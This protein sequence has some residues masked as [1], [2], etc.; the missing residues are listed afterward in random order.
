MKTLL[1][2]T[3]LLPV[4]MAFSTF[5]KIPIGSQIPMGDVAIK[6]VGGNEITLNNMIK[7]NGILVMFSSNTCPF[8]KRNEQRIAAIGDFLDKNQI[9]F[10]M[11]NSSEGQRKGDESYL[12]MQKHARQ[13]SWNWYYALDEGCVIANAFGAERTPECYLFDKEGKLIY[14][15]AINNN[16]GNSAAVTR[17][18]L[19]KAIEEMLAGKD[20]TVKETRS[21]GCMIK[22]MEDMAGL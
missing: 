12:A 14:R 8:V 21:V 1:V 17:E 15:G 16:P 2:S 5:K 7:V 18:H 20:V 9:G 3:I 4:I 19:M 11:I 13:K 10:V 22:R 6:D